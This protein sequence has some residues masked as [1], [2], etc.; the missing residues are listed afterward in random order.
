MNFE[1]FNS[2]AGALVEAIQELKTQLIL[3]ELQLDQLLEEYKKGA[4]AN[5]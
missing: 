4:A 5:D 1:E 3:A 2:A